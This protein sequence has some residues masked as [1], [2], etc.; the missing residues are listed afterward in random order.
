MKFREHRGLLAEA[1]LTCV[2]VADRAA[3]EAHVRKVLDGWI[4]P[5]CTF[6]YAHYSGADERIGWAATWIMT[7]PGWGV[8]GFTDCEPR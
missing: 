7:S 1:M 3:L 2:E 5:D 8:I 4:A 6:E